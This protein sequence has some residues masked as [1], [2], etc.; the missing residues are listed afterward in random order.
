MSWIE[1]AEFQHKLDIMNQTAK[2]K[3]AAKRATTHSN[4]DAVLSVPATITKEDFLNIVHNH[5]YQV[6]ILSTNFHPKQ[7]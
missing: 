4:G 1:L 6:P 2:S 7:Q 3:V 5:K